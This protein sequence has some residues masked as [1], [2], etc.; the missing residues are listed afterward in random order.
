MCLSLRLS[1]SVI[2]S[3]EKVID[4]SMPGTLVFYEPSLLTRW[5]LLEAGLAKAYFSHWANF[6]FIY[7]FI[8]SLLKTYKFHGAW[9]SWNN[10]LPCAVLLDRPLLSMLGLSM[11]ELFQP[12]EVSR[13][14]KGITQG[15]PNREKSDSHSTLVF[16]Q[17]RMWSTISSH[18]WHRKL[19]FAMAKPLSALDL[20]LEP[21]PKSLLMRRSTWD[22]FIPNC[23]LILKVP[24]NMTNSI[25]HM[26]YP[27]FIVRCI[28][29][30]VLWNLLTVVYEEGSK[31]Q[32]IVFYFH[33]VPQFRVLFSIQY[34]KA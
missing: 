18:S 12:K 6:V 24:S 28:I 9:F 3:I 25:L 27:Y 34:L 30:C 31:F 11:K 7:L 20:S 14:G 33:S 15:T 16:V 26:H 29:W 21:F 10:S 8:V 1:N 23:E 4:E 5:V 22:N 17:W 2:F 13:I 19:L 32:N